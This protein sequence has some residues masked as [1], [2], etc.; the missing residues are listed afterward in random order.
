M[1]LVLIKNVLVFCLPFLLT[2]SFVFGG[3]PVN[4][5][6]RGSVQESNKVMVAEMYGINKVFVIHGAYGSPEENWVPWLKENLESKGLQVY[7]PKFPTPEGQTLEAWFRVFENFL[8]L[9]DE[10]SIFVGHSLG[11]AFILNLLE[12]VDTPIHSAYLVAPFVGFLNNPDFD[13]I[14]SSFVNKEFDWKKIRSN[15][16]NFFVYSSDNDPYVPLSKGEFLRDKLEAKFTVVSGAGHFNISTG[17]TQFEEL[18]ADILGD[19]S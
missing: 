6:S 2:Y 17:Y 7:I 14:N 8:P 9:L 10:Q 16:R 3:S 4:E 13:P 11:P 15:C 18:L 1:T 19:L 12:K 5:T